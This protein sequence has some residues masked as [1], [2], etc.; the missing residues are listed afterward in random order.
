MDHNFNYLVWKVLCW[1]IRGL[2][3]DDKQRAVYNKIIE[4]GCA[5]ACFQETKKETFDRHFLRNCYPK[6]FDCSAFSP[7]VGASGGILVV[8]KSSVFE[9]VLVDV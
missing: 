3:S 7:S 9:G 1:N 8:W 4:S 6:Q 5:V 2:N